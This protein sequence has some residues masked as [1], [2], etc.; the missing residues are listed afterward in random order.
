MGLARD[1]SGEPVKTNGPLK[2]ITGRIEQKGPI[3]FAE[4]MDVALYWPDGGYYTS[5]ENRW[6]GRGDYVTN[7]DIS[8]VFARVMA[9]QIHQMWQTLGSPGVFDL[10]EVGAGRGWFT[11]G[12]LATLEELYPDFSRTIR[13]GVIEKNPHLRKA[14]GRITW[15]KDLEEL[16]GPFVGCLFSNEFIDALPFHRVVQREDLKELYV[17]LGIGG[18]LVD[19]EGEPSTGELSGYFEDLGI[20]LAVGQRAEVG[21]GARDWIQK[22]GRIIDRGFVM[23]IDYGM[24]AEELYSPGRSGT[25]MCHFRHTMN[26]DPYRA[27]GC[28]DITSHLDFT[29]LKM[30]GLAVGLKLTGFTTQS[31]FLLGLGIDKELIEVGEPS[32]KDYEAIKHNQG[33][34][35]LIIPGGM[36][37]TFKVF[38]QHKGVEDPVLGGFSIKNVKD[39]L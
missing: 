10:V 16:G 34:K 18:G 1:M 5:P 32:L 39:L 8:P 22:A 25:L 14:P 2:E 31:Y 6:G 9:R 19:V 20:K 28:Q 21:L 12:I 38:V 29:T 36:G 4:F 15:H 33:I 23:T 26:D 27:V 24:P 11:M 30:A 35:E 13:A 17:G 37:D 7:L 3:T